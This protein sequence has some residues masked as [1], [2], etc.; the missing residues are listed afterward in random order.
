LGILATDNAFAAASFAL[1]LT[2]GMVELISSL[3]AASLAQL[4][5][6]APLVA[7]MAPCSGAGGL[8]GVLATS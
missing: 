6:L 7:S 2:W 1:G 5:A 4:L 3:L 8:G